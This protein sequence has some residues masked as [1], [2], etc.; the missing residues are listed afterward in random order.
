L[1]LRGKIIHFSLLPSSIPNVQVSDTTGDDSSTEGGKQINRK[2]GGEPFHVSR[3]PFHD[4][5]ITLA[6][7]Q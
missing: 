4:F 7:S 5:F 1:G 3:L 2:S 6:R